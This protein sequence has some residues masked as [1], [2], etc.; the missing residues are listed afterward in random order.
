MKKVSIFISALML[1]A[2]SYAQTWTADKAHS[3]L[4]FTITH[5]MMSDVDG[6]FKT[7]DATIKSSKADFSD[8]EFSVTAQTNSIFTDNEKRDGH[9]MSPDFFD[10]AKNPTVTFVSKSVKK[11]G[12]STFVVT[13]D[14]TMH[15]ITKTVKLD[16]SF[17]GPMVNPMSKKN[18][19]GF[20]ISG[21]VKRGDFNLGSSMPG[22]VLSDDVTITANGEFQQG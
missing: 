21:I 11:T 8:A 5:M 1:T 22:A 7:F 16:G 15:G 6:M 19:A 18:T 3:K 9:L 2:A 17:R 20:K 4:G 14:L 13:G 10:A 12:A